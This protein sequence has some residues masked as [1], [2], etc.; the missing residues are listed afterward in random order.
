MSL[1]IEQKKTVVSEVSQAMSTA[2][3]VVL[4]E[5]RG[6]SVGQITEL[7]SEARSLGVDVR[8]VKNTLAKR[9]I[10][11]S[12]FE[13]L[14]DHFIGPVLVSSSEDPVAVAKVV[15]KFSKENSELKITVGAMD[16]ELLDSVAIN[17]LAKLPSHDEL[18]GKLVVVLSAPMTKLVQT[19]NEV[20]SQFVRT[21]AA[22]R[23]SLPQ[24][25]DAGQS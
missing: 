22:L 16:S 15:S 12:Q 24:E 2:K 23:D 20:P 6:L 17:E 10:E 13:C 5:Y 4:A 9:S 1:S 25:G 18:L 21:L 14:S 19:M 3:A 11:G 8:V 7:R